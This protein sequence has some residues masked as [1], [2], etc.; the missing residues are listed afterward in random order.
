MCHSPLDRWK[1]VGRC[2][3]EGGGC[4]WI[5]KVVLIVAWIKAIVWE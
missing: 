2:P 4:W 3:P 1:V 5:V